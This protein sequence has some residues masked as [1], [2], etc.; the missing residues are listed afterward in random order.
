MLGSPGI[1]PLPRRAGYFVEV[2]S[3]FPIRS[4]AQTVL[5]ERREA[6][7]SQPIYGSLIRFA[8]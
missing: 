2:A 3:E 1:I 6:A 5:C 7:K 8:R 4:Y